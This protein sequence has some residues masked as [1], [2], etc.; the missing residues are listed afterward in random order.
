MQFTQKAPQVTQ[1]VNLARY[2]KVSVYKHDRAQNGATHSGS[3]YSASWGK[4]CAGNILP[5]FEHN[6]LKWQV[7]YAE[8]IYWGFKSL[9]LGF[10]ITAYGQG[11]VV[12]CLALGFSLQF[13]TCSGF[14]TGLRE[15]F[16]G[17]ARIGLLFLDKNYIH[18]Y[19][20]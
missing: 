14:Q 8:T 16:Q 1:Y 3:V 5:S 17:G 18:S 10:R 7:Q 2:V 9:W 4:T 20:F 19:N 15:G 6:W 11:L 12:Q 13:I